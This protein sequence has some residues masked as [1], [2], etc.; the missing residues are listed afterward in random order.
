MRFFIFFVILLSTHLF[1][2]DVKQIDI[3]DRCFIEKDKIVHGNINEPY[4]V[5]KPLLTSKEMIDYTDTPA[6]GTHFGRLELKLTLNVDGSEKLIIGVLSGFVISDRS[7]VVGFP[8]Y[9]IVNSYVNESDN[10]SIKNCT[11][12]ID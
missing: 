5:I 2:H 10:V 8:F 7:R 1:A 3:T 4:Y 9:D 12:I 6:E 11:L